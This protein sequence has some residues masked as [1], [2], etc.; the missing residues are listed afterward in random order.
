MTFEEIVLVMIRIKIALF[1]LQE[2]FCGKTVFEQ[3]RG[4]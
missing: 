4:R 1:F 2:F 3:K